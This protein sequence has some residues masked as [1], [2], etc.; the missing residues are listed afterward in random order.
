[1]TFYFLKYFREQ[2]TVISVI[3][4]LPALERFCFIFFL[5]KP[6]IIGRI[7][8]YT[9]IYSCLYFFLKENDHVAD[10]IRQ[11]V[12]NDKNFL[13]AQFW[14]TVTL[15]SRFSRKSLKAGIATTWEAIEVTIRFQLDSL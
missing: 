1:M 10:V 12:K 3:F 15:L 13:S 9:L 7:L 14:F 2:W 6:T 11:S 5:V 4:N 8:L